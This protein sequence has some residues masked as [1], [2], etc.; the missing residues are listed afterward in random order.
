MILLAALLVAGFL[1]LVYHPIIISNY[2]LTDSMRREI[3]NMTGGFYSIELPLVPTWVSVK[4]A[5]EPY[6]SVR[7]WYFPFGS[8]D[9]SRTRDGC[10][11]DKALKP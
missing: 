7:I 11:I 4:H 5:Q 8:V 3:H 6:W 9:L 10:S 1:H 2:E